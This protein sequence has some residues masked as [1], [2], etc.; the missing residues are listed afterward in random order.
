MQVY[1]S[2][3]LSARITWHDEHVCMPSC[4]DDL[5]TFRSNL[6]AADCSMTPI[7]LSEKWCF[8]NADAS[9][10]LLLMAVWGGCAHCETAICHRS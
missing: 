8:E 3:Q 4:L 10:E 9:A 2:R 1:M 6:A 7:S 5:L